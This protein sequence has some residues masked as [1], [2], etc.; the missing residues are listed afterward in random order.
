MIHQA[1]VDLKQNG[2]LVLSL[3]SILRDDQFDNFN[4]PRATHGHSTVVRSGG[5]GDFN[6]KC[7]DNTAEVQR[8]KTVY[9]QACLIHSMSSRLVFPLTRSF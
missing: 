1:H 3:K 2:S 9:N 6:R 7:Q 8:S 4:I 5:G